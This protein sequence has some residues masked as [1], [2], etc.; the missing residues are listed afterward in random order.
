MNRRNSPVEHAIRKSLHEG[1]ELLPPSRLCGVNKGVTFQVSRFDSEGIN[2]RVGKD[3]N[4]INLRWYELEGV[5]QYINSFGGEVRIGAVQ[6]STGR[7]GSLDGYLKQNSKVMR[8]SY[9]ASILHEAGI[10]EVICHSPMRLRLRE[11]WR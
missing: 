3:R 5:L 11:D 9:A 8:S 2:L 7:S 4:W 10:A 1:S 6:E